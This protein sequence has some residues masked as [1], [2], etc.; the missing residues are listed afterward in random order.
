VKTAAVTTAA[1]ADD[2]GESQCDVIGPH[3]EHLLR[4][5]M[6]QASKTTLVFQLRSSS[7]S[8]SSSS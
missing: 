6:G 7:S 2:D 4:I 3:L 5:N 8:S 1:A